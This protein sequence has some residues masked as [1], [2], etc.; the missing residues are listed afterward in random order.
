MES[1][2]SKKRNTKENTPASVEKLK[3]IIPGIFSLEPGELVFVY[4]REDRRRDLRHGR[5]KDAC[6]KVGIVV[7]PAPWGFSSAKVYYDNTQS[8]VP[9]SRLRKVDNPI[10]LAKWSDLYDPN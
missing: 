6:R 8:M 4:V 2:S 9:V 1:Q 10:D 5:R 7:E 3:S